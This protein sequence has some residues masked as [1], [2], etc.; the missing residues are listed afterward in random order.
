MET[1]RVLAAERALVSAKLSSLRDGGRMAAELSIYDALLSERLER[2]TEQ[3]RE[4]ATE[5]LRALFTTQRRLTC[6]KTQ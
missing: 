3:E 6:Q 1:T 4:E 5:L 2:V